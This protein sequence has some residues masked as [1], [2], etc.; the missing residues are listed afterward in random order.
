MSW[1]LLSES[2][3]LRFF[4]WIVCL[5][6]LTFWLVQLQ[7]SSILNKEAII[8]II[9]IIIIIMEDFIVKISSWIKYNSEGLSAQAIILF[10]KAGK[11]TAKAK[12]TNKMHNKVTKIDAVKI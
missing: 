5:L 12:A 6:T 1:P 2:C 7:L 3:Y 9:I 4:G 11:K 10:T 8:I